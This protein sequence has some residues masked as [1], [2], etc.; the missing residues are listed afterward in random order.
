[1]TI[2]REPVNNPRTK[3][4]GW[5]GTRP[6]WTEAGS[7]TGLPGCHGTDHRPEYFH[8]V[9]AAQFRFGRALGEGEGIMPTTLPPGLQIPAMLSNDPL[10]L[11]AAV[12][13]PPGEQ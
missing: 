13:S 8:P 5:F 11:T 1:M 3:F 9:G 7:E 2:C 6:V 10:R 4:E 12:I